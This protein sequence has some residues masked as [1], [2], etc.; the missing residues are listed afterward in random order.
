MAAFIILIMGQTVFFNIILN[1]ILEFITFFSFFVM[2]CNQNNC[3]T[4][5]H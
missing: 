4:L 3:F 5:K 2:V 1:N